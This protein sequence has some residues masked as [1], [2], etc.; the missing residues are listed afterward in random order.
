MS[1]LFVAAL[2]IALSCGCAAP[3]LDPPR[4]AAI[5]AIV[6]KHLARTQA[7]G[8]AVG[9]IEGKK[10]ASLGYG[11]VSKGA[12]A[13]P[14]GD[15]VYEIGS[16]TKVFTTYLLADLA[17]EGLIRLNDP[18]KLYLPKDVPAPRS[19]DKEILLSHLA[20]H[21]SGL[22]KLPANL[23]TGESDD[24]YANYGADRLYD[25]LKGHRLLWP[26]DTRYEY[27]NL[28]MGLLGH[29]LERA[30]T[31]T[32]EE[33]VVQR[34]ASPLKMHGTR[35]TLTPA[36]KDRLAPPYDVNGKPSHNWHFRA[37]AGA[38]A[39]RSTV[40]DLLKFAAANLGQGAD[41]RIAGVFASC[42]AVRLNEDVIPDRVRMALGWHQ[43]PLRAGGKWV[44]WHNGA[45]GGYTAFLGFAKDTQT[46]VVVLSN[47]GPSSNPN[48]A[49][50]CDQIGFEILELLNP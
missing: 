18:I 50:A 15:T 17:Q 6:L 46:A 31:M 22:V 10:Q 33:L 35:V 2:A 26:I 23:L 21:R 13:K 16:I 5:D 4:V 38:G 36:M 19:A 37:L 20:T 12:E 24:P 9:I 45:T 30:S 27:S 41:P 49:S 39:I 14:R 28:G 32:Y 47:S 48:E 25:F 11:R 34:I 43:S 44:V 8:F 29:L 1:R 7:T 42:H 40:D 3:P